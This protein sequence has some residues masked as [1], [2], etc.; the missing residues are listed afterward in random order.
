MTGSKKQYK[1]VEAMFYGNFFYGICA[2]TSAIESNLLQKQ[3]LNG[4]GFYVALFSAT[5]LFYNYPYARLDRSDTQY[6]RTL[7]HQNHLKAMQICQITLTLI[8]MAFVFWIL[9]KHYPSISQ[10]S[11][12]NSFLALLFPVVGGLYYGLNLASTKYNLRSIGWLKP[13]VIG[14][15]WAGITVTLPSLIKNILS[16][17][18]FEFST[19]SNVLFLKT[20]MYLSL[21]AIMFDIKDYTADSRANLRTIVVSIGLRKT[22]SYVLL[23]LSILGILALATYG[24][25]SQFSMLRLFFL[26]IPIFLLLPAALSLRKRRT[27]LYY[28]IVIDGLILVKAM[29]GIVASQF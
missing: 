29:F 23:P 20:F 26:A 4:I 24:L 10:L 22:I 7:W 14:F 13:F 8:V 5:V 28:L 17:V 1:I 9:V 2:V 18:D 3:Q 19:Q 21:L 11:F 15:V 12:H 6:P 16:G 27:L 25:F